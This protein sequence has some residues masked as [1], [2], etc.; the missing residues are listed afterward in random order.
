M[1]FKS[2]ATGFVVPKDSNL[3]PVHEYWSP[4]SRQKLEMIPE[5]EYRIEV[6]TPNAKYV[7]VD[8]AQI[9]EKLLALAGVLD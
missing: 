6:E 3:H 4:G 5:S 8:G 9:R 2:Q 1:K 7:V